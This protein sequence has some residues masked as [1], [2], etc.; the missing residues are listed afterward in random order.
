[1]VDHLQCYKAMFSFLD[2]IWTENSSEDLATLLSSMMLMDDKIS[3]DPSIM[4]L[5]VTVCKKFEIPVEK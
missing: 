2:D 4:N 1:M 5:W 3:A